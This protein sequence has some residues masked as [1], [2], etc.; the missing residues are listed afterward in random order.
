MDGAHSPF[1]LSFEYSQPAGPQLG[2]RNFDGHAN[3]AQRRNCRRKSDRHDHDRSA[4][5]AGTYR[6]GLEILSRSTNE[7]D[8]I[9]AADWARRQAADLDEQADDGH[10]SRTDAQVLLRSGEVPDVPGAVRDNLPDCAMS[11]WHGG[12]ARDLTRARCACPQSR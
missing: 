4:D 11:K 8:E 10:L 6:S 1:A 3:R 2:Q 7:R 9:S 12:P 5:P